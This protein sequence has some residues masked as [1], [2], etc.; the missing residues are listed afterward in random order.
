MTDGLKMTAE[1]MQYEQTVHMY[2]PLGSGILNSCIC[3]DL[4]ELKLKHLY[5]SSETPWKLHTTNL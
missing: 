1:D 3:V 4:H 2:V 5:S